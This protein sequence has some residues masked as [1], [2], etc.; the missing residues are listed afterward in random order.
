M[1]NSQSIQRAD[2]DEDGDPMYE[3][4]LDKLI[5]LSLEE[6][7]ELKNTFPSRNSFVF[8]NGI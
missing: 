5:N 7:N 6:K 4:L 3:E 2:S 8:D 1:E